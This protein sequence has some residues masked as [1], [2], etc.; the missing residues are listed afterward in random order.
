MPSN[1]RL[2]DVLYLIII[3]H[4]TLFPTEKIL[5]VWMNSIVNVSLFRFS[6]SNLDWKPHKT[7][8][9]INKL[10]IRDPWNK[11]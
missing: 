1:C 5:Q 3:S 10:E 9:G 11:K 2:L 8:I 6:R 7:N 4:M